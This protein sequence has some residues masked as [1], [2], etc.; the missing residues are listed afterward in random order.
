MGSL[1]VVVLNVLC[2]R[3]PE[4]SLAEDHH[5]N[6]TFRFDRQDKSLRVSVLFRIYRNSGSCARL[7]IS[8][9]RT[10]QIPNAMPISPLDPVIRGRSL[11]APTVQRAIAQVVVQQEL[12]IL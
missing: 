6:Q 9:R 1:A 12:Q 2:D 10:A 11:S 7:S 4:V 5:P 3:S 8:A